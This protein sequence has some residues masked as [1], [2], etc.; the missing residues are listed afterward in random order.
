MWQI[1]F[2]ESLSFSLLWYLLETYV[3]TTFKWR[4]VHHFRC[5]LKIFQ[6]CRQEV[7]C[8]SHLKDMQ[9]IR[10]GNGMF[11]QRRVVT[12]VLSPLENS[13]AK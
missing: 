13:L 2:R 8:F 12:I 5:W 9:V 3:P 10:S 11:G 4:Y 6:S 1:F 7:F